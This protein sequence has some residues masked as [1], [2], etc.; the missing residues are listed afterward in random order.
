MV[1]A[2]GNQDFPS[3]R[4]DPRAGPST[5][6]AGPPASATTRGLHADGGPSPVTTGGRGALLQRQQSTVPVEGLRATLAHRL[7]H[8][9]IDEPASTAAD[10]SM[11]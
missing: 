11:I 1:E 3:T 6:G 5:F 9:T 4:M 2:C 10:P 7:N 8:G